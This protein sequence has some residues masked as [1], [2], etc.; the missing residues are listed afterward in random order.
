MSPPQPSGCVAPIGDWRPDCLSVPWPAV[1]QAPPAHGVRH[2]NL[3]WEQLSTKAY[4]R[5]GYGF[6]HGN[7]GRLPTP[8]LPDLYSA[9]PGTQAS[10]SKAQCFNK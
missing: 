1:L 2:A 8:D 6:P 10:T 9:L 4:N 3:G 5:P 7:G